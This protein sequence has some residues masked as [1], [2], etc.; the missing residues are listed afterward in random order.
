[1]LIV[2]TTTYSDIILVTPR[3]SCPIYI[4]VRQP[5]FLFMLEG[6]YICHV[7]EKGQAV[8]SSVLVHT[9][10]YREL[11]FLIIAVYRLKLS[12]LNFLSPTYIKKEIDVSRALYILIRPCNCCCFRLISIQ[13]QTDKVIAIATDSVTLPTRSSCFL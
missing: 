6:M 4:C 13:S 10:K 7:T 12:S 2:R 11:H 5:D 8:S 1:M 3:I 9:S